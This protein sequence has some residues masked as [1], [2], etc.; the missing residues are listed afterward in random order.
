MGRRAKSPKVKAEAKR[1]LARKAPKTDNASVRDL[2]KRLAESLKREAEARE[3]EA[4]TAEILRLIAS[5]PGDAQPVFDAIVVNALR[6]CD[7]QGAVVLRYDGALMHLAAYHNVNPEAVERLKRQFPL[8]PDHHHPSGR[9]ILDGAIVH[10]PDLPA[11]VELSGSVACQ[12]GAR[13]HVSIPLLHHGR[14]IGAIGISRPTLGP[15]PNRQIDLLKTFADQAVIAIENVRLSTELEA[16]NHDLTVSLDQQVAT[17]EVLRVIA[18]AQTDLQPVFDSITLSAVRL[19]GGVYGAL[20]RFD[21]ELGHLVAF[22]NA[23]PGVLD[24]LARDM[25]PVRP[26]P[27]TSVGR[28]L[29]ERRIVHIP[30]IEAE[31]GY[32]RPVAR[33][34]GFRS[35][36]TVPLFREEALIGTLSV[37]RPGPGP[38]SDSYIALLRTFADQASIAIENV[39]LFNETKE[40]LEQQT[41]TSE[42]LRVI[43]SSPTDVQPV[44][45][46]IAESAF[47]LLSGAVTAVLRRVGDGF[48]VMATHSRDQTV[49][50]PPNP[51]YVPIDPAANF[52]SRVFLGKTMLHIPDWTAIELPV[53]ERAVYERMGVRSSLMLPLLRDADC[54]GVLVVARASVRAYSDKEIA[55]MQSFAEQA[56]I[57]IENVR[58]FT[59]L[60]EKN[61]ALTRAH[62]QVTEALE[63]QT[64]TA[65]ILRVIASSPTDVQPVF[66]AIVTSAVRLCGGVYG[67]VY[68]RYGDMV[69]CVAHYGLDPDEQEF[70]RRAFPRPVTAGSSRHFQRALVEG[71]VV[72]ISDIAAEPD[73]SSRTRDFYLR[74]GGRCVVLVPLV[75]QSEVLGVLGVGHRQIGAFSDNQLALL[76]TFAD[77]AVIAIENVRLFTETKEALERQTATAEI[78]K[79]ISSSPT[80]IQPVLDV[81]AESAARLCEAADA[82]IFRVDGDRIRLVAQHGAMPHGP[83]G[84][85]TL[86]LVRQGV[87]GRSVI[88]VRTVHLADVLAEAEEFPVTIPNARR[89]GFRTM[90][91]VPLVRDGA[92]I[93]AIQVF[94]AEPRL[95]SERQVALLQI[96][97]DQAVIAIENVR[98]FTELQSSNAELRVALEQQ[99][100]TSELLKVIGRSTF[101]LQP[102]FETLAE[103]AV[104]LCEADHAFIF[105][106]DGHVL[107]CVATHNIPPALRAFVEANP[108]PP[109]RGSGAGRAALERRTIHIEDML[110]DPEFT[111]GVTQVGPMRTLLAVPMLR[112]NEL[113]GVIIITRPEVRLFTD[114][115]IALMETFADQA[116]IAIEN[117][118]L[119]TELQA[120][121]AELTRSVDE[122][123]ALGD[124]GRVLGSTLDLETVL[125]TIVTRANQLTGAAGCTIWEYDEARE[126][127]RLRASDYPDEVDAAT[128]QGV[129]RV[130]TIRKGVGVTTE[131][132]ERRQPVQVLDIAVGGAEENPIR[133][134]LIDAGHH[135][136]LGVPL[137][138]EDEVIGVLTV[139][140]KT[141]GEFEP[142]TVRLLSTF[143][144][145]SGLAIQNARLFLEI[146]D[147]SRQLEAASQHKSEFLAN[148]SH[149]LRTPLNA[150]IG[151]SEVLTDRMFGELNEKQDEYLKDIYASG[152][153]LLS[154]INDI[155]DLS[156]IEAGRMELEPTDF[157][158]PSAIDNALTL[159]RERAGRR[160]ITL[161]RE[162]DQRVGTICADE[163]KVKQVVLNLLSNAIKFTPEGGRIDVR[164]AVSDA[165]VEVSVADTGVGIAPEDQEAVFEEFRQVGTA[166]KKVEGTGLGL[167]LSRKFIELHGG[168]ISVQSQVGHGSTFTFTLPVRR[169]D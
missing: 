7:A 59:E 80:D 63:Q 8:A 120:R 94:R 51:D 10:V 61:G 118:R 153:H 168:R 73:V 164:A 48:R 62:S 86:P 14:A 60:Q 136:L 123:T 158:L 74:H 30:D 15:F 169:G 108:V 76:K 88:D 84:E 82:S 150:I 102:V 40:A 17:A 34:I 1:P 6:L 71:A 19:C 96:F 18:A 151:F 117:A 113:L 126:E 166:D 23:R 43:S 12:F 161:G 138:S 160:G 16:R 29:L 110:T 157:D 46:A 149:E 116:A 83:V 3:Q 47:R 98:L 21:G 42:I 92:G 31:P 127:F 26:G 38:F 148:M 119:L 154:L 4:A 91:S 93:G 159:V 141:P 66:A 165:M 147:K 20:V 54:V 24:F 103:N 32:Q 106:F 95:F 132:M 133:R 50:M 139:T 5:S 156:K 22:H 45:D 35:V 125:Q 69:D 57:A 28:A 135:A 145:Q 58:L 75:R 49:G 130:T 90:L 70:V 9:A 97:A 134:R 25:F 11:A 128:L 115:Q 33:T 78:L 105:R 152:Q 131:V 53:H 162:I 124:V 143:A 100:A 122:L 129:D 13:S 52:P 163:R 67:A 107:R 137:V 2:E 81:M 55:L 44:F 64:A 111:Y 101:D 27:G 144:T 114:N 167:A 85:W 37:F 36:I 112:T 72:S 109:G 104:R 121:T 99:T 39:R 89:V 68:R 155:L 79:V 65:E 142:E 87:A 41:A 77:Q 146:E 56:V 140:R